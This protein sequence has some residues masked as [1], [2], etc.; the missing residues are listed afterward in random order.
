MSDPRDKHRTLVDD[1][2]ISRPPILGAIFVMEYT[3]DGIE[4]KCQTFVVAPHVSNENPVADLSGIPLEKRGK[5]LMKI[6]SATRD[7]FRL[8]RGKEC[9]VAFMSID[10]DETFKK[11]NPDKSTILLSKK[12]CF[13]C[14]VELQYT[15]PL[16]IQNGN[17]ELRLDLCAGCIRNLLIDSINEMDPQNRNLWIKSKQLIQ[18]E[19]HA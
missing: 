18:E 2:E 11:K 17:E 7:L 4:E 3:W 15:D 14:G 8:L 12:F 6:K 1:E 9:H 13:R 16:F 10:P 19:D 5:F